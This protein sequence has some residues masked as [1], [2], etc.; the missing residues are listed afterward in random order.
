MLM[1]MVWCGNYYV[2]GNVTLLAS[3]LLFLLSFMY[4]LYQCIMY[5]C[6]NIS[7]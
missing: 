5:M 4:V 3:Q 1:E 2:C 7:Q 6:I